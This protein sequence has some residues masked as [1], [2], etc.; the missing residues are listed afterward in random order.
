MAKQIR[1]AV[2]GAN[3]TAGKEI[4]TVLEERDFPAAALVPLATQGSLGSTVQYRDEDIPVQ[5]IKNTSFQGVDIAFFASTEK[6]SKGYAPGAVKQGCTVIDTTPSFRMDEDVPLIIP[7]INAYRISG[8]KGIIASPSPAAVQAALV[9]APIHR[10]A[11]VLRVVLSTYQAVSDMGDTALEELTEQIADL[12]NFRET[13]SAV[14][15]HQMAFN[16]I[17][18]TAAFLDNAYTADE[19]RIANETRKVL[20]DDAIRISATTVLVPMYYCHSQSVNIETAKK[21]PPDK[22]RSILKRSPG[23]KVEDNPATGI[24]PLPVYATG[25]DECFVGRIREDLSMENGIALWSVSDN[26]RKGTAINAV[27]IAEHLI[28]MER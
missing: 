7:E 25:K 6:I 13:R 16:V 20:E 10:T 21:L 22:A 3:T 24:Y 9:L 12:F 11:V 17:P 15:P 4:I 19:M 5:A 2:A 18:Q 27:Q 26:I 8:H 14:F 28:S 23:I 1:I